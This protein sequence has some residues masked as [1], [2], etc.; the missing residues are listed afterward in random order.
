MKV[1]ILLNF[2]TLAFKLKIKK[3]LFAYIKIVFTEGRWYLYVIH[4]D[5]F[6]FSIPSIQSIPSIPSTSLFI[7][8]SKRS[9]YDIHSDPSSIQSCQILWPVPAIMF[10]GMIILL[11]RILGAVNCTI[12]KFKV[13]FQNLGE[14]HSH[15]YRSNWFSQ[16][17]VTR[18]QC[19]S[20]CNQSCL[21]CSV[22]HLHF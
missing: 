12:I 7:S 20:R 14:W 2:K 1:Y 13:S 18:D 11:L 8:H 22:C 21:W 16:A 15:V 3:N 4:F 5:I 10:F 17:V 9:I 6:E 19:H